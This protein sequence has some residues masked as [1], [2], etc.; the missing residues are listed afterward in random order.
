MSTKGVLATKT[1]VKIV[2][3]KA[4][5]PNSWTYSSKEVG[6][7]AGDTVVWR[8]SG[9]QDHTV[10]SESGAP[11]KFDSGNMKAGAVWERTFGKAGVFNYFCT[12]H[13]WMKA[14]VTV[15]AAGG[16]APPAGSH[17]STRASTT[18]LPSTAGRT[19]TPTVKIVEGGMIDTHG[20]LGE[21]SGSSLT[22]RRRLAAALAAAIAPPHMRGAPQVRLA[23]TVFWFRLL[24]G[25]S[26]IAASPFLPGASSRQRWIFV[27]LVLFVWL[28][29][30]AAL[31]VIARYSHRPAVQVASMVG[32]LLVL[33]AFQA[34]ITSVR[35][36]VLFGYLLVVAFY[37]YMGGWAGGAVTGSATM[38]LTL[39]AYMISAPDQRL[40]VF[41]LVILA[42]TIISISL[43][44]HQAT[45]E[46]RQAIDDLDRAYR[47]EKEAARRL[48]ELNEVQRDFVAIAAHDL[49]TPL[50]VI[51]GI[52]STVT[53][54]WDRLSESQRLD[55]V[56]KVTTHAD[57]L[58]RLV[59]DLLTVSKIESG[60]LDLER[61]SVEVQPIVL[62][63]ITEFEERGSHIGIEIAPGQRVEAN[64]EHLQRILRNLVANALSYGS[65]P[66]KVQARSTDGWLELAVID[67][68]PGV[69]ES[70]VPRLFEKFSRAD[71]KLSVASKGTGLGL[72]IVRGLAREMGGD[73]FYKANSPRGAIFGI[74][75]P[76][77]APTKE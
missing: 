35:V 15:A 42:G 6:I 60:V 9:K 38:A 71:K 18:K 41:T 69:S 46:Q 50:A 33:F 53:T 19:S 22:A 17:T 68:G 3:S 14:T 51:I 67:S 77:S 10:T 43:L 24:L 31:Q 58:S 70:F 76:E 57:R 72:S 39:V 36:P 12:L 37:A 27:L 8:N 45:K 21:S 62:E 20:V 64:A 47:L 59:E 34:L 48:D 2:E 25:V 44:L 40:D 63:V 11:E 29:W 66:V 7:S 56:S 1:D 32:D 74:R 55:L 65:E 75:L 30:A 13:P 23:K 73:A 54:H 4:D 61:E 28:P 16:A 49:R 52:G 26:A 5:D